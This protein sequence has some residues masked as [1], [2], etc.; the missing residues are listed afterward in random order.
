MAGAIRTYVSANRRPTV[1][2]GCLNV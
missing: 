2:C 1:K